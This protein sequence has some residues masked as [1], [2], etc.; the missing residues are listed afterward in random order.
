MYKLGF[1]LDNMGASEF[2]ASLIYKANQFLENTYNMDLIAFRQNIY[3]SCYKPN[4][5]I[6]DVSETFNYDGV[7]IA[8]NL[9]NADY[10][11]KCPGPIRKIF[12]I[13]DLEWVY[14][15]VKIYDQIANVYQNPNLELVAR[16]D[17]HAHFIESCWGAKVSQIMPDIDINALYQLVKTTPPKPRTFVEGEFYATKR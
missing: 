17:S 10:L 7:V 13:W 2:A 15:G 6:M 1:L 5:A 11:A 16:S 8:N 12:Y 3:F 4:F 9:F 14:Q